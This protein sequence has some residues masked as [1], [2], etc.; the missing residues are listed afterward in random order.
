V[1]ADGDLV[2]DNADNCPSAANASQADQ[3]G[4]AVGDACDPNTYDFE[5]DAVGARPAAMTSYGPS[6]Q[7]LS[8]KLLGG[9][10]VVLLRPARRGVSDAF[11][12]VQAGMPRQDVTV[13]VDWPTR[14]P[15]HRSSCG[16]TDATDGTPATA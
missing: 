10:R 11:D 12:R 9:E 3:D 5:A 7:A 15:T 14:R 8:V 2:A 6:A 13:Y 4:N 1:D 16:R